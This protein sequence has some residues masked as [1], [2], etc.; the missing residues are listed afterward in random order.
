MLPS[1]RWP[2]PLWGRRELLDG[3]RRRCLYLS[4]C[5]PPALCCSLLWIG[6]SGW[7]GGDV[8]A[9]NYLPGCF[10]VNF[11]LSTYLSLAAGIL[12]VLFR[13]LSQ[14]PKFCRW[15]GYLPSILVT[16]AGTHPTCFLFVF[17]LNT[18]GLEQVLGVRL[19]T[20]YL[21]TCTDR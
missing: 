4:V 13:Y 21:H 18:T 2:L 6:R 5:P 9:D 19:A 20:P 15:G 10:R 12:L 7:Y 11:D 16:G 17:V 8:E 14:T 3:S 1:P